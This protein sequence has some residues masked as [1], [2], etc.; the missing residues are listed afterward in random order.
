M[1]FEQI[2]RLKREYTDRY[3]VVDESRPEL[4]RFA[5]RTGT[6]KTVNMSGRALVQFP[7]SNNITWYDIDVDF[8]R[9]VDAPIEPTPAEPKK[10]AAPAAAP[11]AK[12]AAAAG[13]DLADI[14]AAARGEGGASP[15]PAKPKAAPASGGGASVEDI[16]AAARGGSAPAPAAPKAGGGS[17]SIEEILAAA[18]GEAA[19][20][21]PK[22]AAEPE[23]E[24]E[25]VAEAP[26]PEPEPEPEPPAAPA[27]A[28]GGDLPTDTAGIIAWCRAND[29][30]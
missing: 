18:R 4:R 1:V 26:E 17:P 21:A 6:V 27:K 25:P 11:A 2:E 23:P 9:I 20:A 30:K 19:P 24:P 8:L 13:G 15:A 12:P 29:G 14:L 7:G 3:V 22:P 28:T 16:L 10:K 5:G